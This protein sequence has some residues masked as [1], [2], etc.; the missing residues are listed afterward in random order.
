MSD[1]RLFVARQ[2]SLGE[3][4]VDGLLAGLSAGV[5]MAAY[6]VLAGLLM[7]EAPGVMLGRFDPAA[8]GAALTGALAHLAT[9]GIYG[10][11]FGVTWWLLRSLWPRLPGV[12]AGLLYGLLLYG[13]AQGILLP[14]S[15]SALGAIPPL[16]FAVAHIIYGLAL[17]LARR[18]RPPAA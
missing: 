17:G 18:D 5:V 3:A 14:W 9:A 13:L 10:A 11:F 4:A 12:A 15:K 2:T 8:G 7:G 6:L 16:H 1:S